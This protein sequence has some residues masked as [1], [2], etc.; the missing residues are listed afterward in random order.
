MD[1]PTLAVNPA[2]DSL[3]AWT[4]DAE[5]PETPEELENPFTARPQIY[6]ARFELVPHGASSG[7][8]QQV[9]VPEGDQSF[10]AAAALYLDGRGLLAA[11]LSHG[12]AQSFEAL[13]VEGGGAAG[14]PVA[15]PTPL[16]SVE[17][18]PTLQIDST[19][20]ATLGWLEREEESTQMLASRMPDGG[21]PGAPV[22]LA[23]GSGLE[24]LTSTIDS[25]GD[26]T[27]ASD[28]PGGPIFTRQW[29]NPS[30][31]LGGNARTQEEVTTLIT[32]QCAGRGSITY[33]LAGAA[34]HGTTTVNAATGVVTYT[35]EAGFTGVD[36]FTFKATSEVG[37]SQLATFTINVEPS[38]PSNVREHSSSAPRGS[39]S[40]ATPRSILRTALA[41][42]VHRRRA[43]IATFDLSASAHVTLAITRIYGR[44]I[45]SNC[46]RT[47]YSGHRHQHRCA[48][49]QTA[50]RQPLG[51]LG[52]GEHRLMIPTRT[53]RRL[54]RPGA[55]EL[56]LTASD[57]A[58]HTI[59][60]K[61][62]IVRWQR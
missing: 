51:S 48:L 18:L 19:G 43:L 44:W 10:A 62:F 20:V 29:I 47:P 36:S 56:T 1:L 58:G 37:E 33:L 39:A 6:T 12:V 59:S 4:D 16:D 50:V 57:A 61:R 27:L 55:Y 42:L 3:F 28:E 60:G 34:A 23:G 9:P 21:A 54:L 22:S 38:P 5:E 24:H 40:P 53:I 13:P 46:R 30:S 49:S 32:L 52:A 17:S 2:G 25:R 31:C 8:A 35:P 14:R 45:G 41:R 15:V 11:T 7:V 26:V